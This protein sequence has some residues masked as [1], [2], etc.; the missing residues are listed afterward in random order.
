MLKKNH[1]TYYFRIKFYKIK[2][3]ISVLF[4]LNKKIILYLIILNY[5]DILFHDMLQ[6]ILITIKIFKPVHN[7]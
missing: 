7:V 2:S 6:Y 3:N 5:A 1:H 4:Y